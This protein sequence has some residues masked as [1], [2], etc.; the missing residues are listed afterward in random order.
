MTWPDGAS[1]SGIWS[2]GQASKYG[3]FT[4]KNGDIYEGCWSASKMSGYGVFGTLTELCTAGSGVKA[5]C[6]ARGSSAGQR[7]PST[8]ATIATASKKAREPS[9]GR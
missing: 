2:F 9:C 3:K 5:R 1:Y 7:A 6:T 8:S 4:F